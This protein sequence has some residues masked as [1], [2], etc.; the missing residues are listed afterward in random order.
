[1]AALFFQ[2]LGRLHSAESTP[3]A[4]AAKK[5]FERRLTVTLIDAMTS[6]HRRYMTALVR[7]QPGEHFSS[8]LEKRTAPAVVKKQEEIDVVIMFE[9]GDSSRALSP[10][11]R[12]ILS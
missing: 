11:Q 10:R 6:R 3:I 1:M 7:G 8:R 9:S 2:Y 12:E 4:R 5:A